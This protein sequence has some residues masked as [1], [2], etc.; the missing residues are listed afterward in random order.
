MLKQA[1]QAG[2]SVGVNQWRATSG[3]AKL[4]TVSIRERTRDT[5]CS[6]DIDSLLALAWPRH[7]RPAEADARRIVPSR[8]GRPIGHAR[9]FVS[10]ACRVAPMCVIPARVEGRPRVGRR[11]FSGAGGK[12]TAARFLLSGSRVASSVR[13]PSGSPAQAES[14]RHRAPGADG[15]SAP[16]RISRDDR[17]AWRRHALRR[18]LPFGARPSASRPDRALPG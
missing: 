16:E 13:T 3:R 12:R 11:S 2:E 18:A 6:A 4:G 9:S 8:R 7:R 10:R 5:S 15:A 14:A 17:P 1:G